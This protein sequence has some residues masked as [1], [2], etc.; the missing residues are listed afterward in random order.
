MLP[1]SKIA[2]IED[3]AGVRDSLGSLLRSTDLEVEFFPSG[4]AFLTAEGWM[5][6]DCLVSDVQ[7]PGI[8]GVTMYRLLLTRGVRV[9]VIFMS[10]L[11][12]KRVQAEV[13]ELGAACFLQK[14]LL[15]CALLRC[16]ALVLGTT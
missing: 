2:I 5:G 11:Q 13:A 8:D 9:P 6:V 3:D 16:I 7:M 10:A 12:D 14:P 1:R 15:G 4:Q